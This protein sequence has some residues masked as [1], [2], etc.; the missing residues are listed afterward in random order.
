MKEI[1]VLNTGGTF[2]KSY[3]ELN[4]NLEVLLNNSCVEKIIDIAFKG[5]IDIDI[6]GILYKD[7][8]EITK[9]DRE[10]ILDAIKCYEK[11]VIVHGTDTI[12]ITAQ[13]LSENV[14]DKT[15]VLTGSMKPFLIEPIESTSNL[16]IAINFLQ[17]CNDSDIFISMHGQVEKHNKIKKNRDIGRFE[18]IN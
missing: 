14:S 16:C 4:G 11:I 9:Q 17:N 7:S 6:K 13:F 5:N 10:L 2:N 12:D 15:I 18:V 8:L 3:N 1:L